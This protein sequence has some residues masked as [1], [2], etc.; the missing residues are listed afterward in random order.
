MD[1]ADSILVSILSTDWR[2]FAIQMEH[3]ISH[4]A[5]NTVITGDLVSHTCSLPPPTIV[6]GGLA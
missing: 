3:N 2:F 5:F 6:P 4:V 1:G